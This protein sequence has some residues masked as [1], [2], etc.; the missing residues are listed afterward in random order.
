MN[1]ELF[2]LFQNSGLNQKRFCEKIGIS[3][4]RFHDITVK[5]ECDLKPKTFEKFKSKLN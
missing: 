2:K 3:K 4:Q 1:D 5:K